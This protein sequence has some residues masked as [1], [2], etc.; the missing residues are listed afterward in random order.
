[1]SELGWTAGVGIEYALGNHWSTFLEYD[2]IGLPNVTLA[3]PTVF[4]NVAT[5]FPTNPTQTIPVRTNIDMVKMG[6]NYRFNL[7][8]TFIANN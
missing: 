5:V 2:H 7:P 4:A 8:G 3:F 1:M 6:V